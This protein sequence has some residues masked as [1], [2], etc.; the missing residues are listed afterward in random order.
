M[1]SIHRA[2][3]SGS[4][5]GSW[6]LV[7]AKLCALTFWTSQ[8][9]IP[10]LTMGRKYQ[11][12]LKSVSSVTTRAGT[13]TAMISGTFRMRLNA[14]VATFAA[15]I[16]TRWLS[17]T[18]S[19]LTRMKY[20]S[21]T[22]F[23]IHTLICVRI[24]QRSSQINYVLKTC[25]VKCYV[26]HWPE[27]IVKCWLSLPRVTLKSSSHGRESSLQRGCILARLSAV[28]WC[29][30]FCTS[31]RILIIKRPSFWGITLSSRLYRCWIQTVLSTV[32]IDARLLVAI[33]TDAG[34]IHLKYCIRLSSLSKS[35]SCNLTR[36][37]AVLFS[38]IF[39]ATVASKMSLCTDATVRAIR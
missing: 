28:G 13:R 27:R 36:S 12:I 3:L 30:D 17:H 2:T 37:A 29:G 6:I 9:Q 21:H 11:F 38:V 23:P 15:K 19:P 14:A 5:L 20:F 18:L 8:N 10:C 25:L 24:L 39:T 31:W 22:V 26:P 4:I 33:L 35:W 32:I 7:R 34:K 1:I 16:S